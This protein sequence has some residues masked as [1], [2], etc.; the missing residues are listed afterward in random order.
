MWSLRVSCHTCTSVAGSTEER[1]CVTGVRRW[2]FEW[3]RLYFYDEP[4]RMESGDAA[5]VTCTYDLTDAPGNVSW[6]WGTR[7]EMCL[8]GF[9][10]TGG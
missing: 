8:M 7:D 1:E 10:V 5:W 2:D 6:G 3:Q 4:V 9:Y